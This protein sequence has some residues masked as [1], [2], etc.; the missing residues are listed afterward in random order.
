MT[1]HCNTVKY[2]FGDEAFVSFKKKTLT[3]AVRK[4]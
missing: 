2:S 1:E 4:N 3:G